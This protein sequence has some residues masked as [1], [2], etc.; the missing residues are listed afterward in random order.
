VRRVTALW[1]ALSAVVL[2]GDLALYFALSREAGTQS[3]VYNATGAAA[4][5]ALL[6]A[7]R[8]RPEQRWGWALLALG[9]LLFC[10]GDSLW[11]YSAWFGTNELPFPSVADVV[12]LAA[13]PALA[14]GVLLLFPWRRAGLGYVLDAAVLA[15]AAAGVIWFVLIHPVVE[16][17]D[18]ELGR[19]VSVAYPTMDFLLL[20]V[21]VYAA[22]VAASWAPYLRLLLL[23]FG[24]LL[25]SDL[26]Y[27]WMLTRD[28]YVSG[29]W[30]DGGWLVSYVALAAAALHPA[31]PAVSPGRSRYAARWGRFVL[32]ASAAALLPAALLAHTT[33]LVEVGDASLAAYAAVMVV[34]VLARIGVLMHEQH[35]ADRE[36]AGLL[37]RALEAADQERSRVARDLHD[38]PI[39]ALT[40][41]TLKLDLLTRRMQRAGRPGSELLEEIR[42]DAAAEIVSL[43]RVM[44]DLRPPMLDERGLTSALADC[45]HTVLGGTGVE[46]VVRADLNGTRPAHDVETLLYRLTREALINIRKHA[47]ARHAGVHVEERHERLYV[48]VEDDGVGF[49]ADR[50]GV[51][52]AHLGLASMRE[53]VASVGGEWRLRSS[54][55]GGTLV[56][57]TVPCRPHL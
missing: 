33:H 28:A 56:E 42:V 39:Q 30:I 48:T 54:P 49:D 44:S 19:V 57:A 43:R 38:G 11:D 9:T 21:L 40:A 3:A 47:N 53:S 8:R 24:F 12:Y 35:V 4:T 37:R 31:D 18:N 46:C 55:G 45:A 15:A 51:D 14:V 16:S 17:V 26:V 52:P 13:Y 36:R 41:I 23:A 22:F 10:A 25:A 5:V 50:A 2:A 20:C 27:S 6:V 1:A 7:A 32:V 34:L 29:S